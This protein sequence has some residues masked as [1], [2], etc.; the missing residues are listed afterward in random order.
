MR[1]KIVLQ[2]GKPNRKGL[3][4]WKDVKGYVPQSYQNFDEAKQYCIDN[5]ELLE[6]NDRFVVYFINDWA[7]SVC[8]IQFAK[9]AK[10][11]K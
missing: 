6:D 1:Y 9:G 3:M 4:N 5:Q 10:Y 2:E 7:I 11:D 8:Y